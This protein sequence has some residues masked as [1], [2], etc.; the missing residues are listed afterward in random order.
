MKTGG[1]AAFGVALAAGAGAYAGTDDLR[2]TGYG[3][4]D[5]S[6]GYVLYGARLND[7]PCYWTYGEL[8]VSYGK[9]ATLGVSLWQ[10]TDMTTR[11]KAEMRRMN[12]W[13]WCAFGR[14]GL[15]IADGW[16]FELE[17]GHVWYKYHGLARATAAAYRTME[18][19]YGRL[20]L[21]NPVATPYFEGYYDHQVYKGAFLQAGVRREFA[22]PLGLTF[23][24]DFTLGG[25]SRNYNACLYPPFDGSAGGGLAF[26]QLAGTLAYWF[27]DHFGV[28]AKVAWVSLARDEI[29]EAVSADG[30]TYANDFIWGTI[31]VEVAF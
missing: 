31:G 29:R 8:D 3:S 25:G 23:T 14:T 26:V 11:R 5:V 17:A 15:D 18:E 4:F 6:S 12:E 28:H 2:V 7:E 22:L 10:N 24:P 21:K 27:N 20:S 19:W 13:D 9:V 1:W 16:R 30:G